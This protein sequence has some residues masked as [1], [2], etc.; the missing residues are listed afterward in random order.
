ME[1]YGTSDSSGDD[2]DSSEEDIDLSKK[3]PDIDEMFLFEHLRGNLVEVLTEHQM[4]HG[5]STKNVPRAVQIRLRNTPYHLRIDASHHPSVRIVLRKM[6]KDEISDRMEDSHIHKK[7]EAAVIKYGK[8]IHLKIQKESKNDAFQM[9]QNLTGCMEPFEYEGFWY[10]YS[11]VTICAMG[12]KLASKNTIVVDDKNPVQ[13]LDDVDAGKMYPCDDSLI[14]MNSADADAAFRKGLVSVQQYNNYPHTIVSPGAFTE[15]LQRFNTP[16]EMNFVKCLVVASILAS[17]A[18]ARVASQFWN[19]TYSV[20]YYNPVEC[21]RLIDAALLIC[22]C[23]NLSVKSDERVQSK[24]S[25]FIVDQKVYFHVFNIWLIHQHNSLAKEL[26]DR[27]LYLVT[28]I[29][30]DYDLTDNQIKMIFEMFHGYAHGDPALVSFYTTFRKRHMFKLKHLD[31][32]TLSKTEEDFYDREIAAMR[33]SVAEESRYI[34]KL[35][36]EE[37]GDEEDGDDEEEEE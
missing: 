20:D 31:V 4:E 28:L 8:G 16:M 13:S 3:N 22:H 1:E 11:N 12:F 14:K 30:R 24:I 23:L 19:L 17:W 21:E 33:K 10:S 15:K 2:E 36:M 32:I 18:F 37:V 9:K 35:K 6:T 5:I 7:T 34:K 26:I 25:K 29:A 27:S